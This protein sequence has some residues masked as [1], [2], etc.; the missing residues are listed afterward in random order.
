[1]SDDLGHQTQPMM[2][3]ALFDEVIKPYYMKVGHVL[4]ESRM[5][6]WLHSCGNNTP[7]LPA[8]VDAGLNV[9]HPVQKGTMD[10][11]EVAREWGEKLTFL[12][13]FDVQH[14][15]PEGDTEAVRREVR[16]LIDTFDRPGGGMCMAAGN[17][18]VTGTPFDNID[19]FLDESLRYGREHRQ[20]WPD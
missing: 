2:S 16:H 8:L 14:I 15:L 1:T 3:P 17:A 20:G 18:I 4:K 10:E 9:F 19:A 6:W 7:L 11:A 12:V 5:H 13:G